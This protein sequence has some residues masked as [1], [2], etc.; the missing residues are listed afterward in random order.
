MVRK[1]ITQFFCPAAEQFYG[2]PMTF[3]FF[4]P[5]GFGN[6]EENFSLCPPQEFC[7]AILGENKQE[8]HEF[9]T[10]SGYIWPYFRKN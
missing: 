7:H 4:P 8:T 10:V 3:I 9:V 1:Q 6:P 2:Q 5:L